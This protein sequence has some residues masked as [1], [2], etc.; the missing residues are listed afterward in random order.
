MWEVLRL[1]KTVWGIGNKALLSGALLPRGHYHHYLSLLQAR[2]YKVYAEGEE[3][4][5]IGQLGGLGLL[6]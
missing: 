5:G 1:G 6:G 4:S 2:L 3:W